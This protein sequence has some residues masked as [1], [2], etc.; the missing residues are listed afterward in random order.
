M[1]VPLLPALDSVDLEAHR[2][3]HARLAEAFT[4]SP[5]SRSLFRFLQRRVLIDALANV[6]PVTVRPGAADLLPRP[7]AFLTPRHLIRVQASAAALRHV[8]SRITMLRQGSIASLIEPW[9]PMVL[10]ALI[11]GP[12]PLGVETN[13]GM[14]RAT[15][16]RWAPDNNPMTHPE[17]VDVPELVAAAVDFAV[18]APAPAISRAGWLAFTMMSIHPFVDGNGRTARM[19]F[20]AMSSIDLELGI[21]WGAVEQFTLDRTGYVDALRAGQNLARYDGALLDAGP[22][23]GFALQC[24]IDGA[25]LGLRRLGQIN[26]AMTSRLEGGDDPVVA[27]VSIAVELSSIVTLAELGGLSVDVETLTSV[28]NGLV[29][30]ARLQWVP[31]PVSRRTPWSSEAFGL[32]I[33]SG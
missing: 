7:R 23:M 13:A 2:S 27:A 22:F 6:Q 4:A 19:L 16:T 31:R 21:D 26:Q 25:T 5:Q 20:Q 32:A 15:P 29:G 12:S 3:A 14:L 9:T 1:N 30:A 33:T 24:S 11:E 10:H 8:D 28:V 18:R 17:P